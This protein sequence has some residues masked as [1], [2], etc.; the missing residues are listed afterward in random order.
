MLLR[1]FKAITL[2]K[3]IYIHTPYMAGT[4]LCNCMECWFPRSAS[5]KHSWQASRSKTSPKQKG[6]VRITEKKKYQKY[7]N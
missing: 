5:T 3:A 7:L 6:F 1:L 2:W 4:L